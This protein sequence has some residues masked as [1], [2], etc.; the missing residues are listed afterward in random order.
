M[1]ETNFP[2]TDT[3]KLPL[4]FNVL[5]TEK[6]GLHA[7]FSLARNFAFKRLMPA[8]NSLDFALISPASH[9]CSPARMRQEMSGRFEIGWVQGGHCP[10]A[11][12]GC[13]R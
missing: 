4:T 10:L 11:D 9:D 6:S 3:V 8:N 2:L 13:N 5:K 12:I 1:Y 7:T